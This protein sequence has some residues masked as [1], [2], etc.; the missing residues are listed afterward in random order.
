MRHK[1]LIIVM[2]G[3]IVSCSS[4]KQEPAAAEET[5]TDVVTLTAAQIKNA[6][7]ETGNPQQRVMNSELKVNGLVDVPPQNIVSVSFPI[8]G[9]LKSTN[10]LPGMQVAKGGVIAWMEDQA[11]VQ[12]QQDYLITAAKLEYLRQ[13]YERQKLLNENNVNA[14]K[15]FQQAKADYFSQKILLKGYS[16]KLKLL[17]INP[18]KLT[19]ATVSRSVPVYSPINGYVSKVNVNIGKY[20]TP[21]DVLF[22]LINPSDMHAALTVFEK[23]IPKVKP[24]QSVLVSFVDE[25]LAEYPCEVLLITKNVNEDRTALVHC[26]FINQPGKLLPGMFLNAKINVSDA[27]VLAVPEDA[28]VRYGDSEYVVE[29]KDNNNFGLIAVETGIKSEG[30]TEIKGAREEFIK[31]RIVL[32]NPYPVLSSL[33]NTA[34]E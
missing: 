11:I 19:E 17:H 10:L 23:D 20:V 33:K 16:E 29:A 4:K 6:G 22:D 3:M 2:A 24:K 1:L 9:Y 5:L 25:P 26:H 18:Q 7:I 31:K 30:W 13:E 12:L 34:E 8:G 15:V 21:S 28:V 32:K 27:M 14:D